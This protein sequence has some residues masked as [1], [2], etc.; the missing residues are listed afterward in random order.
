MDLTTIPGTDE[1]VSKICLGTMTWGE[2]NSEK[3]AH[4]QID[5]ALERGIN[6]IDTAELYPVPSREE[7]SGRT[8]SYIGSWLRKGSRDKIFLATK[9]V[10]YS[11]G[12]KY[13][14]GGPG[15][16]TEQF[17]LA[18]ENSLK[19]LNTDVIDL[20]QV[21]WPARNMAMFGGWQFDP[22]AERGNTDFLPLLKFLTTKVK[23]GK[24]RH[25]GLSNE[26]AY[27]IKAICDIC[28][29]EG[30]ERPKT[31][32][33]AYSLINRTFETDT[34]EACYRENIGLMAYST[35]GFG[36][37]TGKYIDD[38]KAHGRMNLFPGFINRYTKPNTKP[39]IQAYYD[40]A[41]AN[42]L[43]PTQMA[44]AFVNQRWFTLCNII[45]AT[46]LKQLEEN[47]KSINLKLNDDIL[48]QI[49]LIHLSL[50][51][52]AP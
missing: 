28:E 11:S 45:G 14:R 35:L 9:L 5:F 1:K 4:D 3:E 13:M 21:H 17:Q 44:L 50:P 18:L 48:K 47:I 31:L 42:K 6:F 41:K 24:I 36:L 16:N 52:P 25:W 43:S 20:Y 10:A 33:N 38:P 30:L 40:L 29:L 12:L 34:A 51:N 37:L 26:N 32:Q 8:E 2:Q 49:N 46:N 19:R 27:G 22:Q 39:A 23:E 7:T 15:Y